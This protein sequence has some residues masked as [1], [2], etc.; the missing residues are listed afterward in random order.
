VLAPLRAR[1]GAEAIGPVVPVAPWWPF[2]AAA[3]AAIDALRG[4]DISL[5][6]TEPADPP[7]VVLERCAP[8]EVR[9]NNTDVTTLLTDAYAA[10]RDGAFQ[11]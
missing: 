10:I 1:A 6:P 4:A 2:G 5:P 11:P 7:D 8:L 9:L 3:P